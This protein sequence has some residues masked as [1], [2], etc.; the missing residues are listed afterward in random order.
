[1]AAQGDSTMLRSKEV[2]TDELKVGDLWAK[3]FVA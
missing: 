3:V 1:M 2:N